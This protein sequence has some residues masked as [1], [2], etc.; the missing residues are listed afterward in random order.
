MAATIT[1]T[2]H[3]GTATGQGTLPEVLA[4]SSRRN[5]DAYHRMFPSTTQNRATPLP[6]PPDPPSE[7]SRFLPAAR[8]PWHIS[9]SV[10]YLVLVIAALWSLPFQFAAPPEMGIGYSWQAALQLSVLNDNVFGRDFV[11]TYGP[12]GYLLIRAN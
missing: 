2:F 12:L 9:R 8:T 5:C 11:F 3:W 7:R 10:R 1:K 4:D 6:L